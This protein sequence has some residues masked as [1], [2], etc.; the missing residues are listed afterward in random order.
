MLK[1]TFLNNFFA[2]FSYGLAT[3]VVWIC[4]YILNR[5]IPQLEN[6]FILE[7]CIATFL[8]ILCGFFLI[9]VN[10]L[11][12]LSVVSVPITLIISIFIVIPLVGLDYYILHPI[13][14]FL[15]GLDF[16]E[17]IQL[18]V[19]LISSAFPSLLFYLGMVL[20]GL[21]VKKGD[22]AK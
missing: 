11:S 21:V 4:P 7:G 18:V 19:V 8:Y 2:L 9:P 1:K 13:A 20:R 15:R 10:K 14:Y 12:F 6:P 16:F 22:K 5:I 3:A 17:S